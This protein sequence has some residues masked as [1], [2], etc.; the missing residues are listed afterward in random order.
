MKR[1]LIS[2]GAGAKSPTDP[3]ADWSYTGGKRRSH[4]GYKA[5]IG[6]DEGTGLVR[7]AALTPAKVNGSEVVDGLISGDEAAVYGGRACESKERGAVEVRGIDDRIMHMSH[8]HQKELPHWQ[9]KR[10]DLIS[11]MRRK[12]ENVFGT[13]KR[14]YGYSRVRY[15]GLARNG[16]E[17][18][19]K[20]MAYNLRRRMTLSPCV[21]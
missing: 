17:M 14:S 13:L 11:P 7:K 18:W 1:P 8:K 4:F 15:R 9:K 2:L 6:V 12:V 20:L 5:H 19:F 3:D 16:V 10:N 21:A